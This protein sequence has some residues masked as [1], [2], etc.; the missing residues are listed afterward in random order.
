[1]AE[2]H[3]I[4]LR[5]EIDP[6]HESIRGEMSDRQGKTLAFSGWT[7]FAGA[8]VSLTAGNPNTEQEEK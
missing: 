4:E 5:C 2:V 1:M 8:I 6:K 7:E 3:Q